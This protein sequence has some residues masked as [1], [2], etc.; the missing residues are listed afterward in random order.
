MG[1]PAK[2]RLTVLGAFRL[3]SPEGERID[4]AS[5]RGQAL[6]TML[7][8]AGGG[9]RTRSWLQSRL[10]G[11]R[12]PEQGKASLR[13]EVSTLRQIVNRGEHAILHA[14]HQRVW[15]DLTRVAVDARAEIARS[16]V[17]TGELL[18][19]LDIAHEEGFEEWLR[20]ERARLRTRADSDR[21]TEAQPDTTPP[22]N[23]TV[24][25]FGRLPALAILAFANLTGDDTLEHVAEGMS[26]DLI[27]RLARLRWLPV[28]AR[29]SSF[30]WRE[31][32]GWRAAGAALGAR[33]VVTGQLRSTT[34]GLTLTVEL[35][36]AQDGTHLWAS[37]STLPQHAL[38][39]VV[40]DLILGVATALGAR[41][42]QH[43]QASAAAGPGGDRDIRDL[44]WRGKW[45]LNRLTRH[46]AIAARD[47]FAQALEREPTSAEAIIQVAWVRLWDLWV[48]RADAAE[49]RAARKLAQQAVIAD[50]DDARGY[51]LIG[52]AESWLRQPLRAEAMLARAIDLNP[53]LV[54]ARVQRGATYYLRGEPEKAIEHLEL[55]IRLSPSDQNLF[56]TQGEIAQAYLMLGDDR[57]ALHHAEQALL[58]RAGYWMPYIIKV[59]ALLRLD[60]RDEA[61]AALGELLEM[62]PD[63]T[64]DFIDWTP[65]VDPK[66]NHFLRQGM[67]LADG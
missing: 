56:F 41:V 36:D 28:I 16:A 55:A 32:A 23:A 43:A 63:F 12:M 2:Y 53:S 27:D 42:D 9:E 4:I 14:D 21:S 40:E 17:A 20:D 10:W 5:K 49:T 54:M 35:L 31:T 1:D 13:R 59:N 29:S 6:L 52:I 7:A 37:R 26:E 64:A 60:R 25:D 62:R 33:Y 22:P 66:W 46:D 34:D 61:R 24:P 45:H 48:G 19:G 57:A 67:N 39:G 30:A 65:F 18:E 3:E 8:L 51:M 38:H 11:G 50:C 44:I 58:L 15:I 47:C